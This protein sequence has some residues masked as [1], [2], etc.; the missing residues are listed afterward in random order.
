[1]VGQRYLSNLKRLLRRFQGMRAVIGIGI[2]GTITLGTAS[3]FWPI[4]LGPSGLAQAALLLP[5]LFLGLAQGKGFS[6]SWGML[7]ECLGYIEQVFDFLNQSFEKTQP[8]PSLLASTVGG[9]Q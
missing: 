6:V 5:A 2:A 1:M 9:G 4:N 3:V 8:A 7:V